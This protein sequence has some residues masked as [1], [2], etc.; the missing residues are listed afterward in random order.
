MC[1]RLRLFILTLLFS[2]VMIIHSRA[3]LTSVRCK[4]AMLSAP[5]K[6]EEGRGWGRWEGIKEEGLVYFHR[7]ILHRDGQEQVVGV[8]F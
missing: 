7:Y 1:A 8:I 6:E 4:T 3:G 2:P 5:R